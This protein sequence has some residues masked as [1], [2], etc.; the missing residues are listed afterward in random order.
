MNEER[1]GY[2][3]PVKNMS[4]LEQRLRN[5]IKADDQPDELFSRLRREIANIVIGQVLA[6]VKD[7]GGKPVFLIKG[8]VAMS[9]RLGLRARPTKDFDV[10]CRIERTEAVELLRDALATGWSVFTFRLKTEP[11][12]IRE[13]GAL[14]VDIQVELGPGNIF[15]KVQFEMS[16]AEG[17]AGQEYELAENKLIELER[18]GFDRP[19]ELPMVTAAYLVAQKLHACTDHSD[20]ER[21][22]D[23][24]RDLI[25][26]QLVEQSLE[27]EDQLPTIAVACKEIFELRGKHDW[28]PEITIVEGWP[29][30]YRR[31]A[32]ELGFAPTDIEDGKRVVEEFIQRLNDELDDQES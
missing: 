16:V 18:L 17:K 15:A 12:E 19:T 24:F 31:M 8:G 20:P 10:A 3:T 7:A 14:R 29:E 4:M 26:I 28:P 1:K 13:T 25:D 32:G 11:K 30:G 5:L 27:A 6:G 9:F 23:R 21:R 2:D 22:N